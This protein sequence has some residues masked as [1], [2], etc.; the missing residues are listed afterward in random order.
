MSGRSLALI[1]VLLAC[2]GIALALWQDWRSVVVLAV[3]VAAPIGLGV[4]IVMPVALQVLLV[5]VTV[6]V[7]V[8]PARVAALVGLIALEVLMAA[9]V[10][11]TVLQGQPHTTV[12]LL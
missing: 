6:G 7:R 1:V 12:A 2:L 3:R 5:R 8:T 10:I 9:L 11:V 4:A